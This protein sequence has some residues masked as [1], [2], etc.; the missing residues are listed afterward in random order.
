MIL[1]YLYNSIFFSNTNQTSNKNNNANNIK[2]DLERQKEE[3]R[4][5]VEASRVKHPCREDKK[6]ARIRKIIFPL[7]ISDITL[8]PVINTEPNYWRA[9]NLL[10]KV[11]SESGEIATPDELLTLLVYKKFIDSHEINSMC[12][13]NDVDQLKMICL[14]VIKNNVKGCWIETGAWHCGQVFWMKAILNKFNKTNNNEDKYNK[15][16]V[17]AFDTFTHFPKPKNTK[18]VNETTKGES[19]DIKVHPITEFMYENYRS[20]EHIKYRVD[21]L[22][23]NRKE[24]EDRGEII[25]AQGLLED[26]IPEYEQEIIDKGGISILRVDN[27]YYESVLLVLERYYKHINKGGYVIIDDY[28]NN[29]VGCKEATK[30]FRKKHHIKSKIIDDYGGSVYWQVV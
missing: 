12:S 5:L 30:A 29:I 13:E 18:D 28:N 11:K 10:K 22:K 26:T 9:I 8:N 15:R 20:L 1:L 4:K 24:D 17:Y 2:I 19:K 7:Q 16:D 14:D 6:L 27:D 23:L 25:F 3:N 21:Y